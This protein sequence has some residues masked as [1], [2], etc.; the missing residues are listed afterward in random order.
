MASGSES[1]PLGEK[2]A[3][4]SQ[5]ISGENRGPRFIEIFEKPGDFHNS[6]LF[7][8]NHKA[9]RYTK[10]GLPLRRNYVCP[11]FNPPDIQSFLRALC[12]F[13]VQKRE[14]VNNVPEIQIYRGNADRAKLPH[15]YVAEKTNQRALELK[16]SLSS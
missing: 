14:Y 2:G 3:V 6:T 5:H 7:T 12:V 10:Q 8:M 4:F 15:G 13:A 9:T 16:K 11:A 1:L